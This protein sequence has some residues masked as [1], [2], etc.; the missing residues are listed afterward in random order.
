MAKKKPGSKARKLHLGDLRAHV[1]VCSAGKCAAKAEQERAVRKLRKRLHARGLTKRDGGV[2]CTAVDCLHVCSGG[3]IAV[4]WPDGVWYRDATAENLD[5]ILE[6]HI[7]GGK[8]VEKL[9]IAG[10]AKAR[11][12]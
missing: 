12:G 7:I 11:G 4:V 9:R 10:P 1:L 6:K 3:P 2:M 5:R 8:V